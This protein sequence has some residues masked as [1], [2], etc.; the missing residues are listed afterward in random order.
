MKILL[1]YFYYYYCYCYHN[2]II[3]IVILLLGPSLSAMMV[4]AGLTTLKKIEETNPREIEM[5]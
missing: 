1:Y 2:R 3:V 4:N 5:V